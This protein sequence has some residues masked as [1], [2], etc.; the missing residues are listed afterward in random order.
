MPWEKHKGI[1]TRPPGEWRQ[2][3]PLFEIAGVFHRR[4]SARR[5]LSVLQMQRTSRA[6]TERFLPLV[7]R[8]EPTNQHDTNAIA[9]DGQW[10]RR[11]LLWP[12]RL[13]WVTKRVHLGYVPAEIAAELAE[14][15]SS[16]DLA[17]DF[18]D[19]S[20]DH[21]GEISIRCLVLLPSRRKKRKTR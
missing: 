14:S 11:S 20:T 1:R 4:E 5:F 17:I 10:R 19:Y 3:P 7:P 21:R 9:I 2:M 8:R 13:G 15:A 6:Y 12:L 16:S 18:Y